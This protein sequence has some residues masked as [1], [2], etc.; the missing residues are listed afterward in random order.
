MRV[1]LDVLEFGTEGKLS[2]QL[3]AFCED[4]HLCALHWGQ[5]LSKTG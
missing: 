4:S 2:S 1:P 3:V 5:L